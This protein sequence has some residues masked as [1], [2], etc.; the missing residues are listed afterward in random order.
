MIHN[1]TLV[2]TSWPQAGTEVRDERRDGDNDSQRREGRGTMAMAVRNQVATDLD[3]II[4]DK[5]NF[6]QLFI[7]I[8]S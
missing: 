1:Q 7:I 8:A 2:A 4:A 3:G 5:G 6:S